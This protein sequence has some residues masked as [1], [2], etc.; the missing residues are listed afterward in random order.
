MLNLT[1]SKLWRR[2][3]AVQRMTFEQVKAVV[4][5]LVIT[6]Y[7]HTEVHPREEEE[8]SKFILSLPC[9]ITELAELDA[10]IEDAKLKAQR[11]RRITD[12]ER[13]A[14]AIRGDLPDDV[15]RQV[16][17]MVSAIV[18]ADKKIR[19]QE[20]AVLAIFATAF[21]IGPKEAAVIFTQTMNEFG[22]R[23]G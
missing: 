8:F 5:A 11:V 18:V 23:P 15:L 13:W 1:L 3:P 17:S 7:A 19:T 2:D 12:L 9:D 21:D 10:H 14:G 6:V 4:D 16:Y 20:K 22:L